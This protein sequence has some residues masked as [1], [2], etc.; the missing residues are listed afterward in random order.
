MEIYRNDYFILLTKETRVYIHSFAGGYLIKDFQSIL[1]Q[2]PRV[3]IRSFASL[4]KALEAPLHEPIEFGYLKPKIEIIISKDEMVA[5]ARLHITDQELQETSHSLHSQII[6]AM[7]QQGINEGYLADALQ[8][9]WLLNEPF[10]VAEGRSPVNGEDARVRY[11]DMSTVRPQITEED[12]ADFFDMN[13]VD[14]VK[15]GDWMGE[16]LPP[17]EGTSG[18]TVRGNLLLA[19][20]GKDK[21]LHYDPR[22]IAEQQENG[23]TVLRALIHGEADWRNGRIAVLNCLRI[24]GDVGLE[25]GNI[26][27]EGSVKISG[28]VHDRYSVTA[29][30]DIYIWGEAGIGAVEQIISEQG[31]IYIRGGIFGKGQTEVQA[32]KDVYVKS[33]NDCRIQAGNDLYIQDYSIGCTL[34]ARKVLLNKK[35]GKIIGGTVKAELKV[36]SSTTG[37]EMERP[38]TIRVWGF[39]RNQVK[40]DLEALLLLYKDTLDEIHKVDCEIDLY[41]LYINKLDAEDLLNYS[42]QFQKRNELGIRLQNLEERRNTI[43]NVLKIR[44]EGE[45]GIFSKA[46]PKT[47]LQFKEV[48][49]RIEHTT[50]GFFFVNDNR[51]H[52]E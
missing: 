42:L 24:H 38:T 2:F 29:T 32:R 30:E 46:Y 34:T 3:S 43:M 17:T 48:E 39:N 11:Y 4:S 35:H 51:L 26:K 31:N 41:G 7:Q 45:V 22:T 16:Y 20:K 25:T 1:N 19:Q 23:R 40:K 18:Y 37:N 13:F 9:P 5:Q 44:G 12:T 36:T 15:V 47:I 6:E 14:E 10:A 33:A 28:T 8:G 50:A 52:I 49:K 21:Q 27:Y